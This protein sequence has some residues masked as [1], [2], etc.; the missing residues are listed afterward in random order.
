MSQT[1]PW[2]V[3]R[4][5]PEQFDAVWSAAAEAADGGFRHGAG[6]TITPEEIRQSVI[7]GDMEMWAVH[8]AEQ[9]AAVVVI[10]VVG[11]PQGKVLK[12]VL[13]AGREFASWGQQIQELLT[14]YANLIG[15][16]SI[17]A[18]ARPGMAKWLA[19]MGWKRKATVMELKDGR[20]ERPA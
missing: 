7:S 5:F 10:Q 12:V 9:I 2:L 8:D 6:D 13:V 18:V 3:S 4:V 15:A 1:E 20:Q 19:Q 11:R 16:A 17:E 14:E